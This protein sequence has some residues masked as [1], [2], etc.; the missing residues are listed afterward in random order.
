MTPHDTTLDLRKALTVRAPCAG[1]IAIGIKRVENR[2]WST[3]YRGTLYIHAGLEDDDEGL[4]FI[5][6]W[7]N[8]IAA[9]YGHT[10]S[11][12]RGGL[13]ASVELYS[14]DRLSTGDAFETPGQWHWRLRNPKLIPFER[15][16]GAQ[17]IWTVG[18]QMRVLELPDG[19]TTKTTRRAADEYRTRL[20]RDGTLLASFL[21]EDSITAQRNAMKHALSLVQLPDVSTIG[22]G[23]DCD[24]HNHET[25]PP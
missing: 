19:F 21:G 5:A 8:V 11:T 4:N 3:P 18:N 2:T 23:E 17:G 7:E 14:T 10:V 15:C 9:Y 22:T 16:R 13:I 6:N 20:F 25:T 24:C 1:L 12:R